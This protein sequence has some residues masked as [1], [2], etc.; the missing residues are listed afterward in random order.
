MAIISLFL[1]RPLLNLIP[2]FLFFFMAK[3]KTKT[4]LINVKSQNKIKNETKQKKF[5]L[6]QLKK[7][8]KELPMT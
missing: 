5:M 7:K 1:H 6:K 2:F 8:K 3:K 4:N